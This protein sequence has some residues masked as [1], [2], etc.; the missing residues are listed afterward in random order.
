[1]GS[2]T[3]KMTFLISS[4][5]RETTSKVFMKSK[6]FSLMLS[7][8]RDHIQGNTVEKDFQILKKS[9]LLGNKCEIP[10]LSTLFG[11]FFPIS[12]LHWSQISFFGA[13]F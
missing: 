10:A 11:L 4:T 8:L 6:L 12:H 9:N 7:L 5:H 13:F 2:L 3:K 1:M